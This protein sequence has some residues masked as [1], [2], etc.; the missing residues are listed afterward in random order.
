MADW[1]KHLPATRLQ[2]L[3]EYDLADVLLMPSTKS[4]E[5]FLAAGV[6]SEKLHYVGRG[7]ASV[8]VSPRA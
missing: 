8:T 4:A 7:V 6:P 5:T 1:R 2:H 3:T